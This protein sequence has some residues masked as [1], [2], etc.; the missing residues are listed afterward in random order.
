MKR[1]IIIF[2]ALLISACL[3]S[4]GPPQIRYGEDPC[5]E[6]Q[7][8]IN[9]AKFAC[10]Y[11]LDSGEVKLFDDI[12]DLLIHLMKT[13]EKTKEVWVLDHESEAWLEATKAWFVRSSQ[14]HT[15]MG[16]GIVAF[17]DEAVARAQA[18]SSG[19][20]TLI[21]DDLKDASS[22]FTG[23]KQEQGHAEH[24]HH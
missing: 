6:C 4:S 16:H 2:V 9:E 22:G 24:H 19:G 5:D 21:W 18:K 15:P 10:A 11:V 1:G 20:S 17:S 3:K 7:M 14:F 23:K 8:I 12:G 13:G